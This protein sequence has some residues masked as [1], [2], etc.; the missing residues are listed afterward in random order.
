MKYK[1]K[2]PNRPNIIDINWINLKKLLA[3]IKSQNPQVDY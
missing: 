2:S 3:W 1:I